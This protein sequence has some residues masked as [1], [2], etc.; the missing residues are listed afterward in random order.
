MGLSNIFLALVCVLGSALLQSTHALDTQQD[1]LTAHN[2]ARAAVNV[3]PLSCNEK[4]ASYAQNYAN[5]HIGDCNLVHFGG[6]YGK[7]LA[8]SSGDLSGTD[9]VDMWA[10]PSQ[11]F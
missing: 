11:R 10:G 1:Y 9:A 6:P 5:Q 4:L 7:N 3:G 2:I 8:M